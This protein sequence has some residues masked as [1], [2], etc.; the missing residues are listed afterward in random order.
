MGQQE[1]K[2]VLNASVFLAVMLLDKPCLTA[3]DWIGDYR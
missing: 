2:V 1:I 3:L